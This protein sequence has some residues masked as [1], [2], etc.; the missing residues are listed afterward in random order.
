MLLN[1]NQC[2]AYYYFASFLRMSEMV[3]CNFYAENTKKLRWTQEIGPFFTRSRAWLWSNSR[4]VSD[5]FKASAFMFPRVGK[6]IN[7]PLCNGYLNLYFLA[8]VQRL[9]R[10]K[11]L[12]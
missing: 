2:T 9:R 11:E 10:L 7:Y 1:L 3:I 8:F 5:F 4:G 12:L 6:R